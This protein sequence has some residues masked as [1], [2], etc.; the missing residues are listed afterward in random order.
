MKMSLNNRI[1]RTI[2][3]KNKFVYTDQFEKCLNRIY[4][5]KPKLQIVNVGSNPARFCFFYE[6]VY[7]E[8]WSTGAQGHDMDFEIIKKY[9]RCLEKNAIVLIPLVPF[10]FVSEYLNDKP[11]YRNGESYLKFTTIL[12]EEQLASL[13][14][15]NEMK[16][17]NANPRKLKR[18]A[19]K[20]ILR[21]I[22]PDRRIEITDQLMMR[23]DLEADSE[24]FMDYWQ[25]EFDI[26][27]FGASLPLHLKKAYDDSIEVIRKIIDFCIEHDIRPVLVVPPMTQVLYNK[28]PSEFWKTYVTDGIVKLN[29]PDVPVFNY[30]YDKKWQAV[31]LYFNSLFMN[32]RGRKLFTKQVLKDVG[33]EK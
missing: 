20:F 8:N 18:N 27:D 4:E 17:Y 10:S 9:Y 33:L 24:M 16:E 19:W 13:P 22:K 2:W 23:C 28:F 29:R 21:D 30:L 5:N 12:D 7:G 6:N 31:D 3:W 26:E 1:K 14:W 11:E 15:Y 32:L 25:R